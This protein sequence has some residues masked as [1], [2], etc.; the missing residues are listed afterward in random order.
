MFFKKPLQPLTI[1]DLDSNSRKTGTLDI[2]YSNSDYKASK[3][4]NL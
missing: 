2:F 1:N 4:T 3:S